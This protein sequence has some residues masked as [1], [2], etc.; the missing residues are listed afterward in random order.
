MSNTE[1]RRLLASLRD[2]MKNAKLD[3][4][5]QSSLRELDSDIHDWLD[6]EKAEPEAA[7]VLKRARAAEAEFAV[8]HPTTARILGELIEALV[9][10]GV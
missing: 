10:M 5:T 6:S 7:S 8:E 1:I 3:A 9:R 4:E 2:A